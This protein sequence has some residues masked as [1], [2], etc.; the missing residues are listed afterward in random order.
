MKKRPN[1]RVRRESQRKQN[2]VSFFLCVSL[3]TLRLSHF[4]TDHR[5]FAER[6]RG[7]SARSAKP[8]RIGSSAAAE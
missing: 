7:L 8:A 1:R 3:R 2:I 4:F 5:N 6:E